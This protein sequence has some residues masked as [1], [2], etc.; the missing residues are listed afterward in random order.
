MLGSY[1]S[2]INMSF[3]HLDAYLLKHGW[4]VAYLHVRY[5]Q[6]VIIGLLENQS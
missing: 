4:I 1:G 5:S 6:V 3:N 2:P